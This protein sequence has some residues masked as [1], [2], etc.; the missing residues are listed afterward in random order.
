MK[1]YH[2][3]APV[4]IAAALSVQASVGAAVVSPVPEGARATHHLYVTTSGAILRYP[5]V[6]NR[7]AA[8]PDLAIPGNYGPI[9]SAASGTAGDALY[10]VKNSGRYAV[11]AFMPGATRAHRQLLLPRLRGSFEWTIEALAVDRS[12]Y[13]YVGASAYASGTAPSGEPF[14]LPRQGVFIYAPTQQGRVYPTAVVKAVGFAID[15]IAVDRAGTLYVIGDSGIYNGICQE[16]EGN[17]TKPTLVRSFT[18]PALGMS[19]GAAVSGQTIYITTIN[20]TNDFALVA[21]NV[22]DNGSVMPVSSFTSGASN[23][24]GPLAYYGG[25]LYIEGQSPLLTQ[26]FRASDTGPSEPLGTLTGVGNPAID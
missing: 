6:H 15:T 20:T 10:A 5:I 3:L 16:Y 14:R 21:F 24:D 9:A 7:P 8:Q 1:R 2:L 11:D 17:H 19:Y 12:G 13:L 4:A 23:I 22:G 18:S 26:L 25:V